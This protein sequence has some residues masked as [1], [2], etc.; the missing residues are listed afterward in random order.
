[1]LFAAAT[2]LAV[3]QIQRFDAPAGPYSKAAH[4]FSNSLAYDALVFTSGQVGFEGVNHAEIAAGNITA[5]TAATLANVD[6]ALARAGSSVE[7]VLQVTIWL[8]D[9]V[10][11][12]DGFNEV[13]DEWVKGNAP[14]RA[15]VEAK[16]LKPEMLVEVMVVAAR[17]PRDGPLAALWSALARTWRKI[18]QRRTKRTGAEQTR[19]EAETPS[20]MEDE[21][22]DDDNAE[23]AGASSKRAVDRTTNRPTNDI[24]RSAAERRRRINEVRGEE[25]RARTHQAHDSGKSQSAETLQS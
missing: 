21:K 17:A 18:F 6:L 22:K 7:H 1:M 2:L 19:S 23:V 4:R 8:A 25:I 3:G 14:A 15:C 20:P 10:R 5:Q 9:I 16:I 24:K 12:Y 13:Y 11:D